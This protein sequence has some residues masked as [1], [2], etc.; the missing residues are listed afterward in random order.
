MVKDEKKIKTESVKERM[1]RE[2]GEKRTKT[3]SEE[4]SSVSVKDNNIVFNNRYKKSDDDEKNISD[5]EL[6]V[7]S[8]EVEKERTR[9]ISE[10]SDRSAMLREAYSRPIA[11][12]PYYRQQARSRYTGESR[13]SQTSKINLIE[14]IIM[15][16]IICGII[17]SVIVGVKLI[18]FESTKKLASNLKVAISTE[19]DIDKAG[20][21][22]KSFLSDFVNLPRDI[23][24]AFTNK[25]DSSKDVNAL[26][27]EN[28]DKEDTDSRENKN[29]AEAVNT[30]KESESKFSHEGEDIEKENTNVNSSQ[31]IYGDEPE[32]EFRIDEDILDSINNAEDHYN[33]GKK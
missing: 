30:S 4:R 17:L 7:D 32:G 26:Q 22:T 15:Q 11:D 2:L 12:R 13:G 28:N 9:D 3:E 19:A 23:K 18:K 24:N 6:S 10:R 1:L 33:S 20:S 31:T 21:K 25:D 5:K 29:E 16:C 14:K 27:N 8:Y